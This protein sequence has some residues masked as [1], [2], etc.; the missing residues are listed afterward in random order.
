MSH[1]LNISEYI[2]KTFGMLTIVSSAGTKDGKLLVNIKCQCG[3]NSIVRI[4]N[5][6]SGLATSCGCVPFQ[7]QRT[8]QTKIIH[9]L[10]GTTEYNSWN[11]MRN[12]CLNVKAVNYK[13]YGGRGITICPQWLDD[14]EQFLKDM[15]YKPTNKHTLERIKNDGNYEPTNCKWATRKEQRLNQR[16]RTYAKM[17]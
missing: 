15:G 1:R 4:S 11:A 6:K 17:S 10:F 8:R 12:R 2:G 13:N 5:L 9:G 14:P 3:R 16:P 7:A